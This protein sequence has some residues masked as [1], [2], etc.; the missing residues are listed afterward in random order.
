MT[1]LIRQARIFKNNAARTLRSYLS[2]FGLSP[3]SLTHLEKLVAPP[4]AGESNLAEIR[5]VVEEAGRSA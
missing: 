4:P 1:C 3:A 2:E 5:A